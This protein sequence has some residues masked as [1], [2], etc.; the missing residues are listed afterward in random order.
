MNKIGIGGHLKGIYWMNFFL[1]LLLNFGGV[2]SQVN[3][4]DVGHI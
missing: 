3:N 4:I 1:S 2:S